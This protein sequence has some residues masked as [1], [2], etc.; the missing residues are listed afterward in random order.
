MNPVCPKCGCPAR[1]IE[2]TARVTCELNADG[3]AGKVLS[4]GRRSGEAIYECGGGHVFD[5]D[6]R[7]CLAGRNKE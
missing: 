3:E 6:G 2:M 4:V 1:Y 5:K 7:C